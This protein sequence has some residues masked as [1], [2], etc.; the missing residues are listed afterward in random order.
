MKTG[1]I[2]TLHVSA[3]FTCNNACLFCMESDKRLRYRL[4]KRFI[5]S[6]Y[7]YR[8]MDK[9]SNIKRIGFGRGEP[10]LNPDLPEYV[11]YAKKNGFTEIVRYQ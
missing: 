8:E 10:T 2:E 1:K 4:V 3:G 7:M 11:S 9:H 5:A 6:G